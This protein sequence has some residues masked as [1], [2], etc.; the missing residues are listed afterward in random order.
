MP[1]SPRLLRPRAAVSTV[2]DPRAISGLAAW[3][4]ASNSS[5]LFDATSGG[6]TP[7]ADGA[8]GRW[9]DLSGNGR[10]L[11]QGIANNRPTRKV[12]IQNGRDGIQFDGTND[13][14][15][16]ASFAHS[17]PLT[18]FCVH[19]LLTAL[20]SSSGGFGRFVEHGGNSGIAI[21]NHFSTNSYGLQYGSSTSIGTSVGFST[22]TR[23]IEAVATSDAPRSLFFSV[24]GVASFSGTSANTPATPAVLAIS[25]FA[26][27]ES[28]YSSQ[29]VY[30]LCYY[31]R[32]LSVA[33]RQA[34]AEY[35]R[36][37]WAIY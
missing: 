36:I 2:F 28:N 3:W 10:H 35:L 37:K 30:E 14:L 18:I 23:L 33:E 26:G 6:S 13:S 17:V 8:V 21:I 15:A 27:G 1:M 12:A 22:N 31:N 11:T 5:S 4:D 25:R 16:T 9:Q 34:I 24:N 7:A 29:E 20:Q 32:T 19:R